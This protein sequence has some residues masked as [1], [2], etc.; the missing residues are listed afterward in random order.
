LGEI[1]DKNEVMMKKAIKKLEKIN[2]HN[3]D[4]R[5][6][7]KPSLKSVGLLLGVGALATYFAPKSMRD[8][9]NRLK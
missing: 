6:Q 2:K 3:D 5:K 4:S 8:F 9:L 7:D 1:F